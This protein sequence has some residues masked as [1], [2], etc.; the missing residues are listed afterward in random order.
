MKEFL[1]QI[2]IEIVNLSVCKPRRR[3]YERSDVD[4]DRQAFRLTMFEDEVERLLD[5]RVWPAGVRVCD[6]VFKPRSANDVVDV[7]QGMHI[8]ISSASAST[9]IAADARPLSEVHAPVAVVA[10]DAAAPDAGGSASAVVECAVAPDP[11]DLAVADADAVD[12][13]VSAE[14]SYSTVTATELDDSAVLLP[15]DD[16]AY[17][18]N[19]DK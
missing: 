9:V 13:A 14:H 6:W 18:N 11:M 17:S 2:G 16:N 7:P 1:S 12:A 15:V 5:P 3:R 8:N 4:P 10:A 19:G